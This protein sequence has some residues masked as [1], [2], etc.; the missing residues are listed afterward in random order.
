MIYRRNPPFAKT[1]VQAPISELQENQSSYF[2]EVWS[3][4]AQWEG[5][6]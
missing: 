2:D 1:K 5:L 3:D 4:F 6:V